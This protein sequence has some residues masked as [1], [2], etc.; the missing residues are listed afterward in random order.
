MVLTWSNKKTH[1]FVIP[2]ARLLRTP[3]LG[4]LTNLCDLEAGYREEVLQIWGSSTGI[5]TRDLL[6][7]SQE[8]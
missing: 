2:G 3:L 6:H 5:Q 4:P 7:A 1:Y 8:S